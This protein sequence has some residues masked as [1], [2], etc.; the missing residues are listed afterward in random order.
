MAIEIIARKTRSAITIPEI[1]AEEKCGILRQ[2][3]FHL[4]ELIMISVE[5][6]LIFHSFL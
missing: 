3:I 1:V 2:H 5:F 6:L 4:D